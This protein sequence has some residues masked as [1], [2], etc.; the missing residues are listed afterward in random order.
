MERY[1]DEDEVHGVCFRFPPIHSLARSKV[2][3]EYV[4]VTPDMWC[5]EFAR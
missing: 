4:R 1:D 2:S 3:D 5:G